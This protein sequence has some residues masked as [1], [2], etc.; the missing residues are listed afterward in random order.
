MLRVLRSSNRRSGGVEGTCKR[1]VFFAPTLTYIEVGVFSEQGTGKC[2]MFQTPSLVP[3][4]KKEPP[5]GETQA[6][7]ELQG[8]EDVHTVSSCEHDLIWF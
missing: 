6:N 8:A 4:L 2:F 5:F 1:V 3:Q 7:Y